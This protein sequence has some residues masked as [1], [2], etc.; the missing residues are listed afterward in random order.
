MKLK[1]NLSIVHNMYM[2]NDTY[3]ES[4][5][6]KLYTIFFKYN[7]YSIKLSKY[8]CGFQYQICM[9]DIIAYTVKSNPL[10]IFSTILYIIWE[11]EKGYNQDFKMWIWR[12]IK[13]IK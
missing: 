4:G 5:I 2:I 8:D 3:S 6:Y 10:Y 12:R 9:M 11:R 1:K 7:F 13:K